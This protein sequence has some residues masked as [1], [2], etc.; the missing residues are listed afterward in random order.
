VMSCGCAESVAWLGSFLGAK[1]VVGV[2]ADREMV[3]GRADAIVANF[4]ALGLTT[5][6]RLAVGDVA[7]TEHPFFRRDYYDALLAD[8]PYAIKEPVRG[9]EASGGGGV[10]DH[11]AV[12]ALVV[13]LMGIASRTL[14]KGGRVTF[15]CPSWREVRE[16][17]PR[18][19]ARV[20][21]AMVGRAEGEGWTGLPPVPAGLELVLCE[22]QTFSASFRRLLVTLVKV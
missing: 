18:D 15:F 5:L 11:E 14:K 16:R 3:E 20:F 17:D 9:V 2:D 1:E 4:Q 7:D 10:S 13:R 19:D 6:P 22:T 8:P 12:L 21:V